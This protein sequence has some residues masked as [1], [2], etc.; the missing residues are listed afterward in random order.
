MRTWRTD[1]AAR[2]RAEDGIT[3]VEAMIS[4]VILLIAMISGF[5]A[6][7][8][9]SE[10]AKT[11][12]RQAAAAAWGQREI[13]QMSAMDWAQLR[14]CGSAPTYQANQDDPRFFVS[15]ANFKIMDD[16]RRP[17]GPTLAGIPNGVEE[18]YTGG[19]SNC[20]QPGPTP[21]TSGNVTGNV[22]RF[23]TWRDDSCLPTLPD[24][25]QS[26]LNGASLV[27]GLLATVQNRVLNGTTNILCLSN[28]DSKR[29]T[30]AVTLDEAGG[31]GP[32]HPTWISTIQTNPNDGLLIDGYGP[33]DF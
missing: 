25:L 14:M 31:F 26:L 17:T 2:L 24:E 6:L 16:Y 19:T 20:V 32:H 29:V 1:A 5:L 23:I 18:M 13:E 21:F 10:A 3:I 22:Y 9:A 11:A 33:F 27:S 12:E 8:S 15:G 30:V 4:A 7:E 28:Q